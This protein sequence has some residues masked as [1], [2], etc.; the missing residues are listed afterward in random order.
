MNMRISTRRRNPAVPDLNGRVAVVTGG[1]SGLG[2]SHCTTLAR[3][4]AIIAVADIDAGAARSVA[5]EVE[6]AGGRA[7]AVDLDV[8]SW[9]SCQALVPAVERELGPIDVLVNNAGVSKR[10]PLV[11]MDETEWDRL[12]DIN[13]K[14]HFLVTRAVAPG[15]I[16][17]RRGRI[18]NTS[19]VVGRQGFP[20]F[21]HY[22]ASKFA[23]RGLTHSWAAELAPYDITVNAVCPGIVDTP[24]HEKIVSQMADEAN[25][26]DEEAK[27]DFHAGLPLGRPQTPADVSE[28][29][30]Y[31]S[32]DLARNMT[33]CSYDVNGGLLNS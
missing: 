32:S 12:F 4:G 8:T 26:S 21:S 16:E 33:G 7:V 17:R 1:G 23:I 13:A 10:V 14:G 9:D 18:V 28:M 24:L 3:Y 19:S 20:N 30:A 6:A 25:V 29:V 27:R 11:E 5:G 15:M 31:L 22:C 2:A